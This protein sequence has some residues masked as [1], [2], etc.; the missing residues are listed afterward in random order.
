MSIDWDNWKPATPKELAAVDAVKKA[1]NALPRHIFLSVD[2]D[3]VTFY[4]PYPGARRSG[5][6]IGKLKTKRF[7]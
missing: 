7:D 1:I 6:S 4:K 2:R 3:G 5:R